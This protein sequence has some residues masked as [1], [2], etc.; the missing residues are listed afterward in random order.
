MHEHTVSADD[1]ELIAEG[2]RILLHVLKPTQML[3]T[4]THTGAPL[5]RHDPVQLEET[6]YE[7]RLQR[8]LDITSLRSRRVAD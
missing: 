6:Y 3:V 5:K 1:A 4:D 8:E 7:R 2:E